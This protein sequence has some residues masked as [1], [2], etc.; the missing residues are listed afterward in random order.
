MMNS[1]KKNFIYN[2]L[3][4][5][6]IMFI[7]LITTPYISRVLGANGIGTYSYAYSIASYF[8]LF[9][10]LGINNYGN[11]TIARIRD[12]NDE[13]SKSFWSIYAMQFFLGIIVNIFYVLYVFKISN[14]IYVSLSMFFY[15]LSA[16]FDINWLFFGLEK[17]K[18]TV[19]RNTVIK[20]VTTICI[21]LFVKTSNDIIIYC[22][23]MTIGMLFSQIV[24]W[25]YVLKNIKLY[26][27][28]F[29]DV[30]KHI[31]PNLVLFI[32]V[33]AV[34]LFNIMDKIMLGLM[35]SK[36][37]VGFYD[38]SQK[39]IAIPTALITS[40]GTVM[41]PRMSNMVEKDEKQSNKLIYISIIFA[42]FL[43]TSMCFGIMGVSREFVPVFYGKGYEKCIMLFLILLPT[44]LFLAFANVIRTQ[45]LLPHQMDRAYVVSAILGATVNVIGNLI[46]I[47]KYGSI[48]ASIS[49]LLAEA[50]V[51]FYQSNSV[52]KYQPILFYITKSI[53][54]LVSGITMFICLFI[55]S[56]DFSN[57]I[58]LAI[59]IIMGAC[60][61]FI[62][63]ICQLVVYKII[64]KR[65]FFNFKRSE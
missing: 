17:F 44:C 46:M 26:R 6:L 15:V 63:L 42:M 58:S 24:L 56:L 25:P 22:L 31:K 61:Y 9:I 41:L 54:F 59:K 10:M 32:T 57:V 8:V 52:K 7:P 39:I 34:S 16:T 29:C 35:T 1:I 43:S 27:P 28:N 11:R 14:D 30:K 21:F 48:G 64:K 33:I 19:I 12:D 4:Q 47:P 60:I 40:L 37:E 20:I 62:I 36:I 50:V 38:S 5:I 55:V 2:S 45:Y 51:C 23:I 65:A 18:M 3:Y 49:T 13:L 53:P